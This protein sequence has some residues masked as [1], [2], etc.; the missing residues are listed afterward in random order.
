MTRAVTMVWKEVLEMYVQGALQ[1]EEER[2]WW[3]ISLHSSNGVA[4]YLIQSK[5]S[6]A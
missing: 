4:F 5:S 3:D 1:L 2:S 6:P